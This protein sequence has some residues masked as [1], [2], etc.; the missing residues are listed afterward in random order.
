M[1]G[2]Y[3]PPQASHATVRRDGTD[4]VRRGGAA[5]SPT[6][7]HLNRDSFRP[8]RARRVP[9]C[10][11]SHGWRAAARAIPRRVIPAA[12]SAGEHPRTHIGRRWPRPHKP[13]LRK[14][15]NWGAR[16]A[17]SLRHFS[18]SRGRL[19]YSIKQWRHQTAC[20]PAM[21]RGARKLGHRRHHMCTLT[22]PHYTRTGANTGAAS[23]WRRIG[24]GAYVAGRDPLTLRG[25]LNGR[26]VLL[27]A[28][29]VSPPST[30]SHHAK[31]HRRA[32]R[33]WLY[34]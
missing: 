29:A 9:R 13:A 30:R 28:R 1:A 20:A 11:S 5:W 21:G 34:D 25:G 22:R 23:A 2:R 32:A 33:R 27:S 16:T 10:V 31:Q 18:Q 7:R 24:E 14:T 26:R 12:C 15:P 3:R 17:A 4:A 6:S 8:H 19:T